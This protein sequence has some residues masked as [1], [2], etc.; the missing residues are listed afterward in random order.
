VG[1]TKEAAQRRFKEEKQ[2]KLQDENVAVIFHCLE[3]PG[4]G[5]AERDGPTDGPCVSTTGRRDSGSQLG[6]PAL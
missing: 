1:N 3:K 2:K 6:R 4:D 5:V